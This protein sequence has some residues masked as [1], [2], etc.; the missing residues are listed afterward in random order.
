MMHSDKR[1]YLDYYSD[2]PA[3]G[4]GFF[5]GFFVASVLWLVGIVVYN[6]LF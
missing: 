6:L 2:D 5:V 3:P 4:L 1:E